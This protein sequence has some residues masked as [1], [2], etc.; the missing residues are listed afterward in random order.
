MPSRD[1]SLPKDPTGEDNI[2]SLAVVKACLLSARN[3]GEI[4]RPLDLLP[5]APIAGSIKEN[6]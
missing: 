5:Q 2:K 4:I 6:A 3:N 1:A